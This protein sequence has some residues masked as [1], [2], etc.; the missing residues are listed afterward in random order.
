M[1]AVTAT[2]CHRKLIKMSKSFGIRFGPVL[3]QS[4]SDTVSDFVLA[5]PLYTILSL[6]VCLS[7][8]ITQ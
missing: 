8:R 7:C 1:S 4:L 6:V 5:D 2:M 3:R